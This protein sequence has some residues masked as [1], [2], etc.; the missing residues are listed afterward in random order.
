MRQSST[1]LY[2]GIDAL[3]PV[4]GKA[5]AG[6]DEFA[7]AMD[8]AGIPIIWISNRNRF[9]L[10]AAIRTLGHAHPFVAEGASGIYLPEGYFNVRPAK[11]VRFGR[12]T[13]V[14]IAEPLPAAAEALEA[15][16]EETNVPI[17]PVRS[18]SARELAQNSGL[19][20]GDA[21]L[22][23]H[24]DFDELFFFAGASES[25]IGR[26]QAAAG[27]ARLQLRNIG[28]FWSATVG[29][30]L[31]RCVNEL[32]KLYARA[33]RHRPYTV[34]L[35]SEEV[36]GELFPLCDQKILLGGRNSAEALPAKIAG[37]TQVSLG[38]PEVWEM[39]RSAMGQK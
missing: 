10:D 26:F 12:F 32:S 20:S 5:I 18:L 29:A 39:V 17:V 1:V 34:G 6:L 38:D 4:R 9:Q 2:L 36:A 19:P 33:L 11:T 23:R 22:A 14:P 25:D 7:A 3:V 28:Q 24:R 15:I 13:C 8:H 21:E 27:E 37:A 35:A 30:S 16:S 31:A